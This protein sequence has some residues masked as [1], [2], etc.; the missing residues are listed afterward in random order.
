MA[1][2][3]FT[4]LINFLKSTK[5]S[6]KNHQTRWIIGL[7]IAIMSGYVYTPD[8]VKESVNRGLESTWGVVKRAFTPESD[9][10][11]NIRDGA[12]HYIDYRQYLDSL[13]YSDADVV[14]YIYDEIQQRGRRQNVIEFDGYTLN[15]DT[16]VTMPLLTNSARIHHKGEGALIKGNPDYDIFVE[17]PNLKGMYIG[18]SDDDNNATKY[19]MQV[20]FDKFVFRRGKTAI[21]LVAQRNSLITD[22]AF[23]LVSRG[24]MGIW[25]QNCWIENSEFMFP[26]IEDYVWRSAVSDQTLMAEQGL[27]YDPA[28]DKY[29]SNANTSNSQSNRSGGRNNWHFGQAGQFTQIR[30]QA[31]DGCQSVNDV[32]EGQSPR[33]DVYLDSRNSTTTHSYS[34]ITPHFENGSSNTEALIYSR[35]FKTLYTDR[36]YAQIKDVKIIKTVGNIGQVIL[37]NLVYIPWSKNSFE[38]HPQIKYVISNSAQPIVN[39]ANW[40]RWEG[41]MVKEVY[42]QR[43]V[44]QYSLGTQGIALRSRTKI[45]GK[46][47]ESVIRLHGHT[48]NTAGANYWQR[49]KNFQVFTNSNWD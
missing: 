14:Q 36:L 20:T 16:T 18:Y 43:G 39:A 11:P 45:N 8:A 17:N 6:I 44:D 2:Y 38:S 32:F 4:P 41:P 49:A 23:E 21:R 12:Y 31:S 3:N 42:W 37:D 1:R 19:L 9:L 25:C 24:V 47:Q 26:K 5:D 48:I 15:F 35:E 22:C 13:Q 28:N 34:L 27:N 30:I 46:N 40:N 33:Y 29:F 10:K 7:V